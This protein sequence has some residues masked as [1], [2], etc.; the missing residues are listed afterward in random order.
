MPSPAALANRL[1]PSRK[2]L[3]WSAALVAAYALCGFLLVPQL[4]RGHGERLLSEATG[5][6]VSMDVVRFNPFTLA[7]TVEGL[8]VAEAGRGLTAF[9]LGSLYANFEI[10]SLLRRGPVLHEL[11]IRQPN[12]K[13]VRYDDG[14]YN[15]S[16]VFERLGAG[17]DEAAA[18]E[19]A[20]PARF[21]VGNI[22]LEGG[23][24]VFDDQLAGV[25]HEIG[26]L[27]LNLPFVSNLPVKVD[28]FVEPAL[29]ASVNGHA[30]NLTGKSKPFTEGR[31]TALELTLDKLEVAPYLAY[32]PFE[33]AFALVSGHLSTELRVAFEQHADGTPRIALNGEVRLGAV[34]V[35]DADGRR[36]L[37]F[38][39]F[40]VELVELQPLAGQW[41][42]TR[43]RLQAPQVELVRE[44]DGR[45]NLA[46][47]LPAAPAR[48][49]APAAKPAPAAEPFDFL[50]A[51]ARVRDGVVGFEDRVPATPYRTRLEAINIDL[52]DLASDG[53]MPAVIRADFHTDAGESFDLQEQLRLTPFELDGTVTIEALQPVRLRPYYADALDKGEVRDGR[54]DGVV[55]HKLRLN[56]GV[57]EVEVTV[58]SLAL[59]DVVLGLKG[60]KEALLRLPEAS[61]EGA[62][63]VPAR[64]SVEVGAVALQ[65]LAVALVRDREGRLDALDFVA[66]AR[67]A[68]PAGKPWTWMLTRLGTEDGSV[69]VE[70]RT[71]GKPVST[72]ADQIALTVE[73]LGN[74][75]GSS[76]TL[77]LRSRINRRGQ[78]AATGSV[79]LE[80]LK[81]ALELDLREVD[82]LPLQPY[83]LEQ[84]KIAISR[85]A[86]T[87]K[88][89]LALEQT[90]D[91]SIKGRF[92]GDLGVANFASVDRLNANDF[93]RWRALRVTGADLALSP[94]A[95]A[96]REVALTDFHTR[97]ILDEQGRLNLREIR[98]EEGQQEASA[99][100][101]QEGAEQAPA[102]PPP[103]AIRRIV[104]RQGNV[105][106]SDR[107]IRPNY[108]A[109]ISGLT[110]ELT[111]LSSDPATL[112]KLELNGKVDRSAPLTVNGEFNPFREDRRLD[113]A[114]A[115]KDFELTGLT[116][117]SGKYVGYGIEKGKLSA[118]LNYRIEERRLSATNRVFLDQ[119]TFGPPTNSPDAIKAPVQLAVALLQNRRGEIDIH[120]PVSG[121]LDDPQFSIG[122]LVFRAIMNL[123]G[124]AITAP[125]ALL[126]SM[127]GNGEEMS[128]LA[129]DA[130]SPV[131]NETAL[132]R[133][134]RLS[135]ALLDRPALK[136][137]IAG[138]VDA[139]ADPE[140]LKRTRM[141]EQV[142]AEKLKDM[143][144]RGVE[145][146]SLDDIQVSDEEYPALLRTVYRDGD[147]KKERNFIGMIKE[148]PVEQ[149]EAVILANTAVG[150]DELATLAQQRAQAARDWLAEEGGIPA[151]RLF[152]V[153]PQLAPEGEG[154]CGACVRFSL[155]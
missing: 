136:L 88:G 63:I 150:E 110:G 121:T 41:H 6:R 126:G 114:A 21:S 141:I 91:G 154:A 77:D 36:V 84:T 108:D 92:R 127:F 47:L 137:E 94:F 105:A 2:L 93:V 149:M 13:V 143:I 14:R 85:G 45:L 8:R 155:K 103:I 44:R 104:V 117:Y 131:L 29:S 56:E 82:L 120:L 38:D 132:E 53:E 86:L 90:A 112:A 81:T 31:E 67:D 69:R 83:V 125:F 89:Q 59:H 133:V 100:T 4:V 72:E 61:V 50:L 87:T 97:L 111:G 24:A 79:A 66:P 99:G 153:A 95:L 151:E 129:F 70:D 40:A 7:L 43:L 106:F 52:R 152:V 107:F 17:G 16:D 3:N 35:D 118:E 54:V 28:V 34:Q 55:A 102:E 27:V 140:G 122:G 124:K 123:L 115:V 57:P 135:E 113:I 60:R 139:A 12:L 96:I 9:S 80:P 76:G 30:L 46:R 26:D 20:E 78:L 65:G 19:A 144:K 73:K 101:P 42:F 119:L 1:R 98:Q 145:A 18:E 109:N 5:R 68:G 22:Q 10:E 39:E 128:Q 138:S 11:R 71:P 75:P 147:F 134:R 48:K 64:R 130:G 25:R 62:V 37:G 146:P 116:T 142:K 74:A 51:T 23:A 58:E 49:A 32:L 15:W 148:V 33:P